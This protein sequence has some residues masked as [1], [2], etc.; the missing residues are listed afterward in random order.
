MIHHEGQIVGSG[1]VLS[2]SEVVCNEI[3]EDTIAAA[4]VD[5]D[6][7]TIV[8]DTE[9]NLAGSGN[10]SFYSSHSTN[11]QASRRLCWGDR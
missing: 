4:A 2:E 9:R 11:Y 7:D 5:K 10:C 1:E 8:E 6:I 3:V